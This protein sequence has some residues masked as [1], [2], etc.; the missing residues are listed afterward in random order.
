MSFHPTPTTNTLPPNPGFSS[1]V[2]R[3]NGTWPL[4]ARLAWRSTEAGNE[5]RRRHTMWRFVATGGDPDS[6]YSQVTGL[7][8]SDARTTRPVNLRVVERA[9]SVRYS[10]TTISSR[11][12]MMEAQ[13]YAKNVGELDGLGF[14]RGG[15][16]LVGP[17]GTG[18]GQGSRNNPFR[19]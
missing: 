15:L 18:S 2:T 4:W 13:E 7:L 1:G 8:P 5:T 16:Y 9:R 12:P 3:K 11:N 17:A 10:G 19:K 14:D 6:F